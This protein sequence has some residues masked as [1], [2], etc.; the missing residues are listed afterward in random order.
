MKRNLLFTGIILIALTL[1]NVLNSCSGCKREKAGDISS[2]VGTYNG[3]ATLVLPDGLKAMLQ[4]DSMANAI[5]PQKPVAC[6][7]KATVN[8]NKE[9]ELQLEE[10]QMPDNG[11]RIDPMKCTVT[12]SED[13]YHLEGK[14][15]VITGKHKTDYS[16]KGTVKEQK[17]NLEI[18]VPIIPI[19]MEAKIL[20][21]G[22]KN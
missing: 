14:G 6:K 2:L 18:T 21:N 11:V 5:I 3:E 1:V 9:L 16:Q 7:I 19:V 13:S 20:F 15:S 22:E 12:F 8:E 4:M 10:F 17:M